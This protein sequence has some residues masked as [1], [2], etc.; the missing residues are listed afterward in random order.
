MARLNYLELPVRDVPE[1][2]AFYSSAL[3]LELH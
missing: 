1:I 2:K 3:W